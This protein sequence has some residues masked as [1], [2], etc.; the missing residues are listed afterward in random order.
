M[1]NRVNTLLSIICALS[2]F[3]TGCGKEEKSEYRVM[4]YFEKDSYTQKVSN[5]ALLEDNEGS[6]KPDDE[7][8]KHNSGYDETLS[9]IKL[10]G[11]DESIEYSIVE[12]TDVKYNNILYKNL[13]T[14]VYSLN[15]NYD[16]NTLINFIIKT[17]E[18]KSDLIYTVVYTDSTEG[19]ESDIQSITL[20]EML[21]DC[22]KY[23]E[24]KHK[25]G[26]KAYWMLQLIDSETR[27]EV[28]MY[29]ATSYILV[30]ADGVSEEIDMTKYDSGVINNET[31][32]IEQNPGENTEPVGDNTEPVGENTETTD[33]IEETLDVSEV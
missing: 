28:E 6:D 14:N 8:D 3:L 20:D 23:E 7:E 2:I 25:Y 16:K 29:G 9:E 11:K 4:K 31:S 12:G 22:S 15:T 19:E 5:R 17:Y 24:L 10:T 18:A 33:N 26:E 30:T 32:E 21:S 13:Y 1:K 27:L